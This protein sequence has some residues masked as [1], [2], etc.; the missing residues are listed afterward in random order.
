MKIL[1]AKRVAYG[2]QTF[3]KINKLSTVACRFSTVVRDVAYNAETDDF[4]V[5]VKD[6]EKDEVNRCFF[7]QCHV[8]SFV[9]QS[10][11]F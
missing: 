7:T 6:L 2:H 4:T 10:P 5:T 11:N 8:C 1:N 3:Q 9:L